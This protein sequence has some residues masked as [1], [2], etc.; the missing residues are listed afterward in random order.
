MG[1]EKVYCAYDEMVKLGGLKPNP[2]NPNTHSQTQIEILGKI[3]KEQGWRQP[4]KVSKRSGYIVSGH[5]RY[6]AAL[7]IGED[8]VPVDY[9]DYDSE[10]SE[11]ADLLADNRIAEL[12]E[13][14]NEALAEIF[15]EIKIDDIDIEIT[16]Y[17]EEEYNAILAAI[18]NGIEEDEEKVDKISE[19]PS[20]PKAK[21]GDIY[22]LGEH[23]LMCGDS[24]KLEDVERLMAGERANLVFTDPPYG[25]K[26][27]KDGVAND[28]LNYDALLDFNKEWIPNTFAVLTENGSWYCG[29]IDEPLMDIYSEIIKPMQRENRITFRNLITWDKGNGQG[30]TSEGLRM[31]APADE[32]CLFVM[33]GVQG[34]NNNSDNYFEGWEPVRDY[35]LKSRVAMGWDVPTM[36]RIVGHSDLSGDHWT[37]KS[38]FNLPTKEVYNKMK[39]AAEKQRKEA[40]IQNDAFKKE[41]DEVKKE[42]YSTRA[43][44][45]NTHD[46]MNNVWHFDRAGEDERVGHA[47][48]KPLALCERAIKSSSREDEKVLDV[49]GGSGSTL[50]ACEALRRK[51]YMMEL[52]PKW[53]DVIISRWENYT[54]EK[55]KLIERV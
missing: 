39:A 31:Y 30:Q 53:I 20:E 55:A 36:K 33:M 45:N 9:Q 16:G 54:G 51:C 15:S 29:G 40:N 10:E 3:I 24:T 19:P 22:E 50:I 7:F 13:V 27:E 11:M 43:Y 21:Y 28:N 46:N 12:A 32:K 25:M 52:E 2:K 14:D 6:E 35:L 48:P 42:Y 37:N 38:Q 4:I 18:N 34:F 1:K 44:F 23:R 8:E 47:T 5:G 26:K 49:F 17:T 41:Y